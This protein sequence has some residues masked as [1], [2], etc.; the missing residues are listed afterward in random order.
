M[1]M[2]GG[3][4]IS[5]TGLRRVCDFYCSTAVALENEKYQYGD[6]AIYFDA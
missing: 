5:A 4:N 2:Y 1:N 6:S 3:S